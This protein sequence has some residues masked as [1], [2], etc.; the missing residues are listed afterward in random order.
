[1][2]GKLPDAI[3][4]K[5]THNSGESEDAI[6]VGNAHPRGHNKAVFATFWWPGIACAAGDLA[7]TTAGKVAKHTGGFYGTIEA[8]SIQ[9]AP[10]L[11][12]EDVIHQFYTMLRLFLGGGGYIFG[13]VF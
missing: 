1:M 9:V 3:P 12:T 6:G 5:S 8:G 7:H 10:H 4:D 13:L 11:H 2:R